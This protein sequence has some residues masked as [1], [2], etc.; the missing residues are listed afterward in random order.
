MSG[1]TAP[2]FFA[3]PCA[4]SEIIVVGKR[5]KPVVLQRTKSPASFSSGISRMARSPK[6]VAALP[7]PSMLA[8]ILLAMALRASGEAK[9]L[10]NRRF[11][12]GDKSRATASMAPPACKI[13]MSPVQNA[14][15]P[16]SPVARET[17]SSRADKRAVCV[18][19]ARPVNHANRT[20]R[21]I[22][23]NHKIFVR[24]PSFFCLT[25]FVLCGIIL[26]TIT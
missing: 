22:R 15:S 14:M 12:R 20:E 23:K 25:E 10:G 21:V 3:P 24:N 19:A 1:M 2:G 18:S 11:K 4:R 26:P 5:Q 7:S 9:A 8:A 13:R 17:A 6:G 16:K